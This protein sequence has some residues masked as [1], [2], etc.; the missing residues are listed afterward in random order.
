VSDISHINYFASIITNSLHHYHLS[1]SPAVPHL[2][3]FSLPPPQH[4]KTWLQWPKHAHH[5]TATP[6][7]KNM[8]DAVGDTAR[9]PKDKGW[10]HIRYAAIFYFFII[11]TNWYL[12]GSPAKHDKHA[13]TGVF[14]VFPNPP[15]SRPCHS[16]I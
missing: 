8:P 13:K 12:T 11:I 6:Q 10:G 5:L 14:V 7:V 9:E 15:H 2:F 1:V 4:V 3:P 16:D